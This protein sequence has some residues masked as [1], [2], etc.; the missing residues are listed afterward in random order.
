MA[1]RVNGQIIP[2]EAIQ[3]ELT[4]LIRFYAEHISESEIRAQMPVLKERARDQAIGAK[5]LMDEATRL[6]FDIPPGR[7]ETK[8]QQIITDAGGEQRFDEIMKK[9]NASMPQLLD[10]IKSGVK[11]DLLVEKI[12]SGIP[13]P[14]ED[15]MLEHFETH[16]DEYA[17]PTRAAAQHILIRVEGGDEATRTAARTRLEGLRNELEEGASFADLASAHSDCPSGKSAGGS[18]GWFG[19][20]AMVPEFDQAVFSMNNGEISDIIETQFGYHL[21]H[22]TGHEIGEAVEFEEARES[23][24][25]FLRHV[26]RG[27]ALSSYV[28][29]L[30]E[31][32]TIEEF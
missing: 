21:I 9:Q 26:K 27:E 7:V 29:E 20:G 16:A 23:I 10:S 5:L 8:L 18:L 17:K 15:E 14:G 1:T 22:K 32:A 3:Y 25:D 11:V 13:D 4:R 31:K 28:R 2:E 19:Q 24:R 6:D 30:R 12:S